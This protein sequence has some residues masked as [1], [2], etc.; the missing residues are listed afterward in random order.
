M[1]FEP[2]HPALRH[3]STTWDGV[4]KDFLRGD[5]PWTDELKPWV[6]AYRG[7]SGATKRIDDAIPEPFSGR[8]DRHPKAILLALN[9]GEAFMGSQRWMGRQLMSDLQSRQGR[10]SDEIKAG[11]GSYTTW[12]RR[13]FDWPSL[14]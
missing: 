3:L 11:G 13:P 14:N 10:F 4:V 1:T 5:S 9:P 7:K 8:L 12:A 2:D 6:D